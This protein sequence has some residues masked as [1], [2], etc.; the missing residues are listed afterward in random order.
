[1]LLIGAGL[2]LRSFDRLL[3]TPPGFEPAGVVTANL[4]LPDSRYP[5]LAQVAFYDRLLADLGA[6]P[7]VQALAAA[8][9]LP[10]SGSHYTISFN[11]EGAPASER[12][13]ADFGT[14]S[15]GYF[16]AMHIPL[17]RGRDFT[18]ADN[19][20][21]PRVV[22][23]NE[24]FARR[25]FP[26]ADPIGK[27]IK[28]GLSTTEAEAPWRVVV[29]VV[30]DIRHQSLA[31]PTRPGYFV[32]YAQ[33]LISPLRLVIRTRNT[34][35]IA[36]EVRKVVARMDPD[37]ALYDVKTMEEYLATSVASPR[38]QALLLALFAGVGLALTAVG[39]YG[40]MAYGVAQRTREFGIRLALGAR[41]GE[42]LGLVMGRGL[43]LVAAGLAIGIVAAGFATQLLAGALYGVDRLD[44][45]TFAGVAAVLLA[46]AM[47]AS[48]LPARRA[49]LVDPISALRSE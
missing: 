33:G 12:E 2:L 22:V 24:T 21:A 38:F 25:Y 9:P 43:M 3:R 6:Q 10:L 34:R 17:V 29:G 8:V 49:T 26:D 48:Y 5:Y 20:A 37:V 23:V 13:S 14:V 19:D 47:L 36:D 27:R 46:V 42:V 16:R 39:L 35:G 41:P 40:V 7:D 45:A 44:P 1:V 32:P 15:P 18:A 4:Q 11:R 28:P 31:E 30:G